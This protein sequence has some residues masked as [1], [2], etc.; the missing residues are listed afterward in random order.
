MRALR[1]RNPLA[2]FAPASGGLDFVHRNY[3]YYSRR[4]A[5]NAA[6]VYFLALIGSAALAFFDRVGVVAFLV[7]L[8]FGAYLFFTTHAVARGLQFRRFSPPKANEQEQIRIEIEIVNPS[9]FKASDILITDRFAG[10][11]EPEEV[12]W[13]DEPIRAVR[14]HR[15]GYTKTID[16]GMGVFDYGPLVATVSDPLGIFHFTVTEDDQKPTEVF[17]RITPLPNLPVRGSKDSFNYGIYDV[18]SR[19]LSSNFV[20]V[21]GYERGDS[22]RHISWK[23]SLKARKLLVKEF[24]KSVNA[25]ITLVLDMTA[26]NQ[27]GWKA[28]STWEYAKDIALSIMAREMAN[29]NHIALVSNRSRIGSGGGEGH[30]LQIIKAV[31]DLGPEADDSEVDLVSRA[32][33]VVPRGTTVVYIGPAFR[34]EFETTLDALVRLGD[35]SIDVIAV[36]LD[37]GSFVEGKL[38]GSMKSPVEAQVQSGRKVLNESAQRLSAA[39]VLTYVIANRADIGKVML[40]PIGMRG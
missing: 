17:P 37:A 35:R 30:Y 33:I 32:S 23:L 26:Q 11:L 4:R 21:R 15:M 39:G 38:H 28:E 24:E 5:F 16:A 31:F 8:I 14:S 12:F 40:R 13:L 6:N 25:E 7:H 9:A 18:A 27:M 10:S 20:G 29:G 3:L 22:L 1:L 19:G 34:P 2:D 36:L